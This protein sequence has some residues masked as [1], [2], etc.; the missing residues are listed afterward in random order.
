MASQTKLTEA[1]QKATISSPPT[2]VV[3]SADAKTL[4]SVHE[5]NTVHCVRVDKAKQEAVVEVPEIA[6]SKLIST[7]LGLWMVGKDSGTIQ[8]W[9]DRPTWSLERTIGVP[10]DGLL[11]D[12][13]T[14]MDFSPDGT[15]LVVGSGPPSRFGDIKLFAVDSGQLVRDFGQAHSDTVLTIEFSPDGKTIASGAADKIIGYMMSPVAHSFERWKDI[16]IMCLALPGKTMV[17]GSPQV[18]L[19]TPSRFGM[20]P[21]VSSCGRL[22]A[23]AKRSRPLALSEQAIN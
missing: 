18:A 19:I 11:S 13:V 20:Y 1:T 9:P 6:K 12:R 7:A 5:D 14:S 8:A 3:F 22:G 16:R 21:A 10:G 2:A 23:L 4:I 15:Q 17:N